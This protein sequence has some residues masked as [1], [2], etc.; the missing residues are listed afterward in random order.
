M[1]YTHKQPRSTMAMV[2]ILALGLISGAAMAQNAADDPGYLVNTDGAVWTN[3]AG[4][5]WRTN[6]GP[7]SASNTQCEPTAPSA[8]A[9]EP[10]PRPVEVAQATP[11]RVIAPAPVPMVLHA[12][13]LF[14]LN[15]ATIRPAGRLEMDRFAREILDM[16][17]E[18]VT[19]VGHTDR[20]GTSAYNMRL[21]EQRADAVKAYLVSQGMTADRIQTMGRGDTQPTTKASDCSGPRSERL[22]GC[23]QP[24]RRVEV[25][26][27]GTR[28][29]R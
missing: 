11:E 1:K 24:D 8:Q 15:S 27:D 2:S 12:D 21:S 14:D 29:A 10:A 6:S 5:C 26:V 22:I 19:V 13:A 17:P 7:T 20:L 28:A 25:H 23:L 16:N 18:T 3:A 9:V 4:D